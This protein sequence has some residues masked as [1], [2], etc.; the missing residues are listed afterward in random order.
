MSNPLRDIEALGQSIWLDNISRQLLDDGEL[1][2]ADREGRDQRGD[3]QSDDLREGHG[4]LRPLRRR[5]PRA[6]QRDQRRRGDLQ[7]AGV[8]GHPRRRRPAASDVGP[9]RAAP[10]ATCR[11]RS[12][13][14]WR[15]MPTE[16][17]R[18]PSTI[19]PRSIAPNVLIKVPGTDRGR[20]RVRGADRDR[21]ERERHAAVRGVALRGDRRGLPPRARAPCRVRRLARVG[22]I[23]GEL[24]RLARGQARSTPR[25]RAPAA[26]TCAARRRWPTPRSPTARSSGSSAVRAG[27]RSRPRARACSGRCGPR[28]RPRTPTTRTRC[29]S[30]S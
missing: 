4:P 1:R 24:L 16:R 20:P 10:T 29:T 7:P 27:R 2:A 28:P 13:P 15:T 18:P 11:S 25:S 22:R 9:Q 8:Q 5:V 23:G 3:L 17:S 12:R 26:R 30:T 6:A 14:R 21:P 19:A